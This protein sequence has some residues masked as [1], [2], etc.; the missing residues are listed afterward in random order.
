MKICKIRN[1]GEA[2]VIDDP[3]FLSIADEIREPKGKSKDKYRISAI[4]T[5][6]RRNLQFSKLGNLMNFPINLR[7]LLDNIL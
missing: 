7:I 6:Y 4:S 3:M 2:S 1:C 5:F